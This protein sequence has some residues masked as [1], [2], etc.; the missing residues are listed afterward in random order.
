MLTPLSDESTHEDR[1][2]IAAVK[3]ASHA[4]YWYSMAYRITVS[5][6]QHHECKDCQ[7]DDNTSKGT[8]LISGHC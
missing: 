4:S 5:L 8:L 3:V 7:N 6:K 1:T 2:C